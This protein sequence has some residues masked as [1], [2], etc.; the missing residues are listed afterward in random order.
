MTFYNFL[1]LKLK[2][3]LEWSVKGNVDKRSSGAYP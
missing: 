2:L 3:A 1:K